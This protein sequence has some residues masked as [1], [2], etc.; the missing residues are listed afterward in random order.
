MQAMDSKEKAEALRGELFDVKE[1]TAAL[2]EE[3]KL[4]LSTRDTEVSG[5]VAP[6]NLLLLCTYMS[7]F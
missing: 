4:S 7:D 2:I 5:S 3:L 1:I 6:C